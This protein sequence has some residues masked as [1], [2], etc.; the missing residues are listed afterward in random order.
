M[1]LDVVLAGSVFFT[2]VSLISSVY[3]IYIRSAKAPT[4]QLSDKEI[5]ERLGLP[6]DSAERRRLLQQDSDGSILA[7]VN[8]AA[9]MRSGRTGKS[10]IEGLLHKGQLWEEEDVRL[11]RIRLIGGALAGLLIGAACFVMHGPPALLYGCAAGLIL[12]AAIPLIRLYHKGKNIEAHM[13]ASILDWIEPLKII[14]AQGYD[15]TT[16]LRRLVSTAGPLS[17]SDPFVRPI[18]MALEDCKRGVPLA[19][20]LQDSARLVDQSPYYQLTQYLALTDLAGAE[21]Q[22]QLDELKLSLIDDEKIRD[23]KSAKKRNTSTGR[24]VIVKK[25]KKLYERRLR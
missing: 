1:S 14:L 6:S 20:A 2:V 12:G 13:A 4:S 21:W 7:K 22:R 16:C 24:K 9:R 18:S 5:F 25:Q 3:L 10:V 19:K 17:E 8:Q 15:L 11:W 23:P